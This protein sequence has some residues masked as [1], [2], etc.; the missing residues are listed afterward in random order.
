LFGGASLPGKFVIVIVGPWDGTFEGLG[1]SLT[2]GV[3]VLSLPILVGAR[4][5]NE[6]IELF[7]GRTVRYLKEIDGLNDTTGLM[8]CSIEMGDFDFNL[9]MRVGGTMGRL[10]LRDGDWDAIIGLAVSGFEMFDGLNEDL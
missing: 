5:D 8:L 4:E 7:D 6:I 10:L 2:V 9:T 1:V 3:T